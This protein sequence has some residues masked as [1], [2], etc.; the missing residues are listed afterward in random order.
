VGC[1]KIAYYVS[2]HGYGHG[3]RS[4]DIIRALCRIDGVEVELTSSLPPAFLRNRLGAVRVTLRNRQFDVGMVQL[5]SIRVDVEV[6]RRRV[7]ELG[8]H[9]DVLVDR[10]ARWL[11]EKSVSMVVCDIPAIPICAAKRVGMP[12]LVVANFSWDWIYEEFAERDVRWRP[13]VER[14][15]QAYAQADLLLKLPFSGPMEVFPRQVAIPLVASPGRRRREDLARVTGADPAHTWVLLSFTT[16]AWDDAALHNVQ[17][18]E[19]HEFFTVQPL[20]WQGRNLHAV[21]RDV[22]PFSDV[23][24]SVDIVVSKPGFGLLSECVVNR[25]P[26][27]YADRSDFREYAI[28]EREMKRY[29]ACVHMPAEALYRGD[30]EPWL[31]RAQS[32]PPPTETLPADGGK[33]AAEII[34]TILRH[35]A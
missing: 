31:R 12:A 1:K 16:L 6:T 13:L 22:I 18:I 25:K 14:F 29:L 2:A 21:H 4:A 24:A 35:T 7:E 19:N 23:L 34:T 5:D 33:K 17:R 15:A 11:S 27:V 28:L 8:A 3:V 26:L 10:E 30:L 9:W 20:E 32:L